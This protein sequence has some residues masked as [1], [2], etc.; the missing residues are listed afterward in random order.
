VN[1]AGISHPTRRI[2]HFF[3]RMG[4]H[5]KVMWSGYWIGAIAVLVFSAVLAANAGSLGF[6]MPERD[7]QKAVF[8]VTTPVFAALSFSAVAAEELEERVMRLLYTFSFPAVYVI[9]EKIAI[10]LILL[11]AGISVSAAAA[12]ASLP[13]TAEAGVGL[14]EV[15]DERDAITPV[16]GDA[17][18]AWRTLVRAAAPSSLF[19]GAVSAAASLI[20]RN[21][22]VGLGAG[23]GYWILE[24]ISHGKWTGPLYLFQS[25]WP[26]EGIDNEI[27]ALLLCSA[28]GALVCIAAGIVAKGKQ[29]LIKT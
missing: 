6:M 17:W 7:V 20:G 3:R 29:W 21:V 13:A 10:C 14:P 24:L 28:A 23:I 1:R 5:L 18:D 2:S 16:N 19:I 11:T 22:L 9:L 26:N 25:V 12:V 4:Y 8:A 15:L 27:N